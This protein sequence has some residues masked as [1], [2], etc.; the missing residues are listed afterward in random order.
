VKGVLRRALVTPMQV[1]VQLNNDRDEINDA[2]DRLIE[3]ARTAGFP[4]ASQFALRLAL[5]EAVRNALVHGHR[6][7]PDEP[8]ELSWSISGDEVRI[9]V[10]DRGP[11]FDPGALPDP[12]SDE[13]LMKPTGRGVM[14]M[15]AY[16]TTVE[17]N[18]AGNRVTMV[19]QRPEA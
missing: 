12:T 1:N 2:A 5:E 10:A 11:G 16:M 4:E 8:V 14:L 7:I 9:S 17:F 13:N 18:D 15:R 3:A 6:D 19:Y